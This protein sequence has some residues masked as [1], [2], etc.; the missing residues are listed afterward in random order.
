MKTPTMERAHLAGCA[1]RVCAHALPPQPVAHAELLRR[2]V[3]ELADAVDGVACRSPDAAR[4]VGGLVRR[5]CRLRD[6]LP[7]NGHDLGVHDL[8]VEH[9][10]V[11]C[12]V[13]AVIDVVCELARR[14]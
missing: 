10:A 7:V 11:E 3:R 9:G 4:L 6:E 2:E 14:H 1:D 13:H 8:V 5:Q 12:A